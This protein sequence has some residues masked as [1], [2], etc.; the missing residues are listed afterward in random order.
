MPDDK[1]ARTFTSD[2]R[3]REVAGPERSVQ[4]LP[5]GQRVFLAERPGGRRGHSFCSYIRDDDD[6]EP[7]ATDLAKHAAPRQAPAFA[8]LFTG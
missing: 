5:H 3:G 8:D 7:L 4:T 2:R 1:A 6:D